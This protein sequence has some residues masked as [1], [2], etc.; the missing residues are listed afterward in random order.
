MATS[1]N[2]KTGT[3]ILY[4]ILAVLL[5]TVILLPIGITEGY[6]MV[7]DT[8]YDQGAQ[9]SSFSILVN[10]I[11]FILGTGSLAAGWRFYEGFVFNRIILAWFGISMA[12]TAIFHQAP[13]DPLLAFNIMEDGWHSF[14][15]FSAAFSFIILS[16]VTAYVLTVKTQRI[17]ALAAGLSITGLCVLL[18]RTGSLQG[19]WQRIMFAVV[20]GWLIYNFRYG[21]IQ[22]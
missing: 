1:A 5:L 14:F 13:A 7:T 20:F 19:L 16:I 10:P 12:M 15:I 3:K 21:K 8:I 4:M 9:H 18:S 6:S 22:Q 11:L 17:L 2:S